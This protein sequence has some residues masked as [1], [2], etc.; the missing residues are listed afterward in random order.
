MNDKGKQKLGSAVAMLDLAEGDLSKFRKVESV[1]MQTL[2]SNISAAETHLLGAYIIHCGG[3]RRRET[4][5][6][7]CCRGAPSLC[8]SAC[9]GGNNSHISLSGRS[10][11]SL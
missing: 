4:F 8:L 5:A 11:P 10:Q 7:S 1:E 6:K 9:G 2:P 3:R